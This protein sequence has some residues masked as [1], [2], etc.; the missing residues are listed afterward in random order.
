MPAVLCRHALVLEPILKI[1]PNDD[2]ENEIRPFCN[3]HFTS[4]FSFA[5][6]RP[7]SFYGDPYGYVFK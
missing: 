2:P 5:I 4:S 3:F 1:P 6:F 7:V